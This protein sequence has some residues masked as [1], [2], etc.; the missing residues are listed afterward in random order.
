MPAVANGLPI[1]WR[2]LSMFDQAAAWCQDGNGLYWMLQ[3]APPGSVL[4]GSMSP[5]SGFGMWPDANF[6]AAWGMADSAGTRPAHDGGDVAANFAGHIPPLNCPRVVAP[7]GQY[8]TEPV[9]NQKSPNSDIE[10][11]TSTLQN[12]QSIFP[13]AKIHIP[14]SPE[15]E[16]RPL[17]LS[18]DKIDVAAEM[19]QVLADG[20]WHNQQSVAE[21]AAKAEAAAAAARE[22]KAAIGAGSDHGPRGPSD[23]LAE[24]DPLATVLGRWVDS[25]GSEYDVVLDENEQRRGKGSGSCTV[26]TTRPNGKVRV[27]RWL[28][29]L[30]KDGQ[31]IWSSS[32]YLDD[33]NATGQ[34]IRWLSWRGGRPFVW[35]RVGGNAVHDKQSRPQYT[36]M[37]PHLC[38]FFGDSRGLAGWDA[39]DGSRKNRWDTVFETLLKCVSTDGKWPREVEASAF[40]GA[41]AIHITGAIQPLAMPAGHRSP[42]SQYWQEMLWEQYGIDN[43]GLTW[44]IEK[45]HQ[46]KK[47]NL[48][49]TREAMLK[50]VDSIVDDAPPD[51]IVMVL[52]GKDADVGYEELKLIGQ[53]R[54]PWA[55]T[56]FLLLDMDFRDET[57]NE[58]FEAIVAQFSTRLGSERV[59]RTK[60]SK[61][62]S[63]T[64]QLTASK[65]ASFLNAEHRRGFLGHVVAGAESWFDDWAEEDDHQSGKSKAWTPPRKSSKSTAGRKA[66]IRRS[67]KAKRAADYESSW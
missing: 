36:G 41:D 14:T 24:D 15:G 9:D 31:V 35:D 2:D 60:L 62:A 43:P 25:K 55:E 66:E 64:T 30:S 10:P 53:H 22:I 51:S 21:E 34:S 6:E 16:G 47:R 33:E 65:A 57:S 63:E 4:P 37:A 5:P 50:R 19:A 54:E 59:I 48:K 23:E 61:D 28:I 32:Y 13:H 3:G 11:I 58:L 17:L 20:Q 40:V 29:R 1:P 7:P 12:L 8:S 56:A 38:V 27:T 26:T 44:E 39:A 46:D 67:A 52:D 45:V 49:Q 18:S 42:S